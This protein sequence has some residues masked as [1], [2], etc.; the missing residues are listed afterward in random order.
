MSACVAGGCVR[1][2][3]NARVQGRP[4]LEELWLAAAERSHRILEAFF[5]RCID[6]AAGLLQQPLCSGVKAGLLGRSRTKAAA[7][8][9]RRLAFPWRRGERYGWIGRQGDQNPS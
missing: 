1:C 4:R 6:V 9:P 2:G 8:W 7:C 5:L 3:R